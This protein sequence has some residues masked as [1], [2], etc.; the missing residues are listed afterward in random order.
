[1]ILNINE[2]TARLDDLKKDAPRLRD[3]HVRECLSLAQV[4]ED[5][6]LVIAI[7]KILCVES[8]PHRWRSVQH[9]VNPDRIGAV[10]WLR[11]PHPAGDTIYAVREGVESQGAAAIEM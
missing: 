1:M 11:L 2:C 3:V 4:R 9:A 10:I 8:I 5:T 6:A 7:Q